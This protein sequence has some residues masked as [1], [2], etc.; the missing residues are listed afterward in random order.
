ML[1]EITWCGK[2]DNPQQQCFVE[3]FCNV[4]T[5]CI[6]EIIFDT[7]GHNLQIRISYVSR[8][9]QFNT[10]VR[11]T[12]IHIHLFT[13]KCTNWSY[14]SNWRISI[15]CQWIKTKQSNNQNIEIHVAVL[16]PFMVSTEEAEEFLA[17]SH[18]KIFLT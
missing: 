2:T 6:S 17:C 18:Y 14:T 7:T 4:C 3:I 9:G 1:R 12:N 15:Y 13:S 10:F 8:C 11:D 16:Y 5:S